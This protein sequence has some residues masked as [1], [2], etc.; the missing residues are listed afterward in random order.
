MD[1]LQ[2]ETLDFSIVP[3][4]DMGY[5]IRL[6]G[7]IYEGIEYRYTL[8]KFEDRP[9]GGNLYFDYEITN[10]PNGIPLTDELRN[11]IS[12]ISERLVRSGLVKASNE[13]NRNSD[14]GRTAVQ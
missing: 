11:F 4:G 6:K 9:L 5:A 13:T 8:L 14:I 10:N 12:F 2:K 7:S 3:H 1:S